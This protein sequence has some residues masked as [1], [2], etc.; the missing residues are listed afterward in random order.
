MYNLQLAISIKE[1]L[2][3][4]KS[5]LMLFIILIFFNQLLYC[6]EDNRVVAKIGAYNITVDEFKDRFELMPHF[7]YSDSNIDSVKKEFLYSL[8]A[9]KLWALEADELQLDT[10][11]TIKISLQTL[12]NL[13]VK[14]E[15]YKKEVESKVVITN[16]EISAGLTRVTRVLYVSIITSPDSVKIWKLNN[17]LIKGADFDSVLILMNLPQI[18]FEIKY[19]SFEDETVENILYSLSLNEITKPI[20]SKNN[21]FIFKLLDDNQDVSIDPSNEHAKN[22]VI[23]KLKD[24]KLQTIG[25]SFLDNLLGG[26]VISA[27]RKLF[28]EISKKLIE[29]LKSRSG[30]TEND[31]LVD[32]QLL[33]T[34]ILRV[35]SML[36]KVEL[37]DAFI[38]I[39]NN[40]ATLKEFLIYLIY[41]KIQFNSLR[42]NIVK[43]I[44]NRA[45]KQFIEDEIIA[46]EGYK[47]G[48]DKLLSVKNDLQIWKNYYLAEV[49]MNR[50][51]D[52]IKI[53]DNE[54]EDFIRQENKIVDDSLQVNIVEIFTDK[55]NDV[56]VIL[57]EL[58]EGKD[59]YYLASVYN[60]REW[61]KQS[62][63]EWGLFNASNG[64]E[65]GRIAEELE[66]GQIY[67]PLKVPGGY[68]IFKLI[69]KKR[70]DIRNQNIA[71]KENIQFI[72]IKLALSKIDK[73][74]NEK[75]ISLAE[76]FGLSVDEQ[77]LKLIETS[78]LN[79]FTYRLIG[80]GGKIAAFPI[81][82]PMFDWYKQS[83]Q[84]NKFP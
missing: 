11:E 38:K 46:R 60:K 63:G 3:V 18:P 16:K 71:E 32:I 83:K 34:D 61:T 43:Q 66:I 49:L 57:N 73:L 78:E 82:I 20:N 52:S 19:G 7:N 69:D 56:E 24:K 31:S 26:K 28:N 9:E 84:R 30:K 29:V 40:S 41:Q 51:S 14:D 80:F 70:N 67:G 77:L 23:K 58:N 37:S 36:S 12:K 72:R 27:D 54:I 75:T 74:I 21:W 13:F 45:V 25:R 47:R 2:M 6:Q 55:L 65:I 42:Q 35:F 15:L 79:T 44:L 39:E 10:I 76:K 5:S 17:A 8:V 48:L 22:I 53:T 62:N 50:Y 4:K 68:S 1:R 81:A 64:G 59:F 33:Q